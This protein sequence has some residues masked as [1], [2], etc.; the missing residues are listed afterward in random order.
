MPQ[1]HPLCNITG[2][3]GSHTHAK[4]NLA[5]HSETLAK[6]LAKQDI[7]P[8]NLR[9]KTTDDKSSNSS[10]HSKAETISSKAG[11]GILGSAEATD[12]GP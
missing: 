9:H 2:L 6:K 4:I 8:L 11:R 5:S 10:V 1:S 3:E 7:R 12:L